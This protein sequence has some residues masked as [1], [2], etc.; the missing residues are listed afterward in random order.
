M[1]SLSKI[2]RIDLNLVH[3]E[4]DAGMAS[5]TYEDYLETTGQL[6]RGFAFGE[7]VKRWSLHRHRRPP[8][9]L[10]NRITPTLALAN[11]LRG[12]MLEAGADGLRVAA[13]YRPRGGS[14]RSQHKA[15]AALDLDLIGDAKL[16]PTYY[17]IAAELWAEYGR[18]LRVGLGFY[19]G[20]SAYGGLRVHLDTGYRARTWQYRGSKS[21]RPWSSKWGQVPLSMHLCE[22]MGL[23]PPNVRQDG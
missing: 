8:R 20:S 13:A 9:A 7:L 21:L 10:W 19:C 16:R 11:E 14:A 1:I 6:G 22:R 17:R 4:P 5:D 23:T 15:N 3:W 12:R 18:E 2:H